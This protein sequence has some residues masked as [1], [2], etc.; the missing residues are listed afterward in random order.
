MER[1]SRQ[2]SAG[3]DREVVGA[4][5]VVVTGSECG[6]EEILEGRVAG[7]T[8]RRLR[9]EPVRRRRESARLRPVDDIDC[10][11]LH[12]V[13]ASGQVLVWHADGQV[14][15]AVA[16]EVTAHQGESEPIPALRGAL[17]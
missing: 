17:Q 10:P 14:V 1:L 15:G 7:D 6:S 5:T 2:A 8:L 3:S 12:V 11:F 16:V 4:I 9:K 13:I